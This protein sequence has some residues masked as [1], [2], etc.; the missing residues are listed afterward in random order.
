MIRVKTDVNSFFNSV[1]SLP[2]KNNPACTS[3][4]RLARQYSENYA[5]IFSIDKV[6]Y[7]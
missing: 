7:K 1:H 6:E 2:I 4:G 3:P 5:R